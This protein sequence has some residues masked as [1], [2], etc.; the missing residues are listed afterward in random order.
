MVVAVVVLSILSTEL[1]VALGLMIYKYKSLKDSQVEQVV[2]MVVGSSALD[3]A[4]TIS[5]PNREGF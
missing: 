4:D 2:K 3:E 1:A 5:F